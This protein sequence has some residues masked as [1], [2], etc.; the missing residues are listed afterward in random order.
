MSDFPS[1]LV[2]R[3]L[4]RAPTVQPRLPSLFE[5]SPGGPELADSEA[6]ATEVPTPARATSTEVPAALPSVPA[7]APVSPDSSPP[8][9]PSRRW[10]EAQR[11]P[12]L[13]P[14]QPQSSLRLAPPS[15]EPAVVAPPPPPA[16]RQDAGATAGSP[17]PVLTG[18]R[19]ADAQQ[20]QPSAALVPALLSPQPHA[21]VREP[22]HAERAAASKL[23][24]A[25]Q[26]AGT[27][28]IRVTIG[29]IEVR[30]VTP[31]RPVSSSASPRKPMLSLEDYLRARN[32]GRA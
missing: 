26:N 18:R 21:S 23:P 12:S 31:A 1:N 15:S 29:R 7:T 10:S 4:G 30:L 14:A 2:A 8:L 11:A 22:P 6:E 25:P 20:I 17:E 24:H 27:P 28:T 16:R 32:R 19:P 3:A 5:S 9:T 13:S